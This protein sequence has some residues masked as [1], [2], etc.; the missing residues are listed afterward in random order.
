MTDR[1]TDEPETDI[2]HK[3]GTHLDWNESFYF[4]VYDRKQDI[5]AFMRIG[6]RPNREEKGMFCY[7][8]MPDGST[9]GTRS[10]QPLGNTRLVSAGLSFERVV[11]EKEWKLRFK[12][13]MRHTMGSDIHR[14]D[15]SFDFTYRALSRTFDYKEC[16]TGEREVPDSAN[17]A[18]HTEQ[19]GTVDGFAV[20]DGKTISI[21]GLGERDHSWGLRDWTAPS[22]WVWLS[23][24]FSQRLA[25][26]ATRLIV[27]KD[28]VDGGFLFKDGDNVPLVKTDIITEYR[29]DGGPKS[30]KMWLMEKNG[31][32]HELEAD[33]LR[34]VKMPFSVSTEK[35]VS[36]MYETLARFKMGVETGY[37]IAE[38]LNRE[39]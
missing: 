27:G 14:E 6:L 13:T 16:M 21:S 12:G 25:F 20:I 18:E 36:V 11:P 7:L 4:N 29:K 26:N 3:F 28:V 31:E 23:C 2:L 32:V 10:T 8:L 35:S 30:I 17:A 33:I 22:V 37:G 5:C 39:S 15:V 38:Y 9:L 19:T 1:K 34:S 24:Q